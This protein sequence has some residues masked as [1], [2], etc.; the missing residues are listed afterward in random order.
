M[1]VLNKIA[2]STDEIAAWR[3][4]LHAHPELAYDEHWTSA[5][6][7]GKLKEFGLD[8]VISGLGRTGVVGV[9]HG[10]RSGE[11]PART[12]G[13]RADMDALPITEETGLPY[14]STR[15]GVMH[16]CGHD[17]HT[18]M[19]LGAA[20]HLAE[21]RNFD[22]TVAFI[23]QPAEEGGAGAK[24]MLDDGLL[25][26]LPIEE[27]Y[28]MHNFPDLPV[29]HFAICPGPFMASADRL[30]IEIEGLGGHAA[31]PHICVDP[32]LAA[33]HM[34]TALQSVVSRNADPLQAAVISITM[35]HG[36]STDN[37]IPERVELG[38]T[39]RALSAEMRDL[40]EARFKAIVES[41]AHAFG[42][43][44]TVT[45]KRDYP[46]TINHREQTRFAV[47]IAREVGSH[48]RDDAAPSMGAEDFAFMLEQRPG[49]M[50]FTGNGASANLHHPRY[51]FND[52]V[53]P[54]GAS[55]WVRLVERAL[56][57]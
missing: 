8:D 30:K 56:A 4:D 33:S 6:V 41:T 24:A 21:T 37:V 12:I 34:V 44:A 45:Y 1:P 38:G 7:A 28:G 23:F 2:Q 29:G 19:L 50:I 14:A 36:G 3:R 15:P 16:A 54:Y 25:E 13:L 35:F 47:D 48:V 10:R 17:G 52:S 46:V 20:R 27:V 53:I 49:A 55:Y 26:R 40:I 43:K 51:D 31:R 22:G 57:P 32:I 5:F 39:A 18:A 11:G 9:L 42:V